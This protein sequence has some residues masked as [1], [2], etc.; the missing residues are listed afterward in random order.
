MAG[1]KTTARRPLSKAHK[2]IAEI[3]YDERTRPRPGWPNGYSISHVASWKICGNSTIDR[4]EAGTQPKVNRSVISDLM[5]N[6]YGSDKELI[7]RATELAD[8]TNEPVWWD[9]YK[10]SMARNLWLSLYQEERASHILS[11]HFLFIPTLAQ[12]R[13][14][15]DAIFDA[16]ERQ[17]VLDGATEP[18][19]GRRLRHER[20]ER[21]TESEQRF[22][23]VIGEAALKLN[24]GDGVIGAQTRHLLKLDAQD[25]VEIYVAPLS[26][27]RYPAMESEFNVLEF[28]DDPEPMV[29]V[30]GPTVTYL[31]PESQLGRYYMTGLAEGK[32]KALRVTEFLNYA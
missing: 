13:E 28:E 23:C 29:C 7:Q 19:V 32:K 10:P 11:H 25:H 24:L 12:S 18:N 16:I 21:W 9:A 27:G 17:P 31:N 14:Y 26:A 20:I 6:V 1:K 5:L 4:I 8:A 15:V 30:L 22:T 2:T 3:M